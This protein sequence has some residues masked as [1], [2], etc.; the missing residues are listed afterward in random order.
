LLLILFYR[1]VKGLKPDHK[2]STFG[3]STSVSTLRKHL[4][5]NHIEQWV[6]ACDDLKIP[7][8]AKGAEEPVRI[9][10]KEPA[11]TSIESERPTYSKEAFVDAIV[12][13]VVGD[14]QVC[15]ELL[16]FCNI[17]NRSVV[18]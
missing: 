9:F 14:D 11:S 18:S 7:I 8:T 3:H 15:I 2:I 4:Y 10:R 5:K 17:F 13:F 12:D 16:F 6:T 1:Q